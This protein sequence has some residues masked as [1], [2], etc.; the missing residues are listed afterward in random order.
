MNRVIL[1]KYGELTTKKG[2]RKLFINTLYKN[3]NEKLKNLN[4]NIFSDISRMYIE[5][6]S[7]D[8]EL[9]LKKLNEVFGIHAYLIAYKTNTDLDARLAYI[10]AASPAGPAP[11]IIISYIILLHLINFFIICH[12]F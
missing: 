11:I 8:E 5:Y 1:I 9:I 2:N 4:V 7:S 6:E 3:I 10:A 12:R